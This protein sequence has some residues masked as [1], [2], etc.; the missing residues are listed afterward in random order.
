MFGV[1]NQSGKFDGTV[2]LVFNSRQCL[3]WQIGP[4]NLMELYFYCLIQGNVW[5]GKSVR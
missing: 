2:L 4:V 5:G 1:A 3:G